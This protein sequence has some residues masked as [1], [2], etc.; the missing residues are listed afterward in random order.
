MNVSGRSCRKAES[1]KYTKAVFFC[2]ITRFSK[3]LSA[4]A[5]SILGL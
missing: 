5:Q 3:G 4:T 2:M 1:I